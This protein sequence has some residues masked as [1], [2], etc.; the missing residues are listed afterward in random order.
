MVENTAET[1]KYF[2]VISLK[3]LDNVRKGQEAIDALKPKN[4]GCIQ[5]PEK[6]LMV[7]RIHFANPHN[8]D[9]FISC[10]LT[11]PIHSPTSEGLQQ[12]FFHPGPSDCE[13]LPG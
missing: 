13:R 12:S 3:P 7:V 5:H 10:P 8:P 9:S 6:N 2:K 11:E 4:A 1:R